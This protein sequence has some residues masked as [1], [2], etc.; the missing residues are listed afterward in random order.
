[1]K[2][3]IVSA[4]AFTL[5]ALCAPALANAQQ[6]PTARLS[7][8]AIRVGS[9]ALAMVN[10]HSRFASVESVCF[11]FTFRNDLLDP[12]E[13]L[14]VTP[15]ALFPSMGGPAFSNAGT[16]PQATRT[17]CVA[18]PDFLAIFIDGAERNIELAMESGSVE[19]DHV[20]VTVNGVR[21]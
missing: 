3:I 17:L 19:I 9:P 6:H 11:A 4:T 5:V 7:Q 2:R 13:L 14:R 16:A 12:G 21:I 20:D 15:L 10:V 1:V 8:A 18:D